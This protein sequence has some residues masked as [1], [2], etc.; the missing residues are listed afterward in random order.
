[1]T[2]LK[3]S[4]VAIAAAS[5]R[6]SEPTTGIQRDDSTHDA[7]KRLTLQRGSLAL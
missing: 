6:G 7:R 3:R 5:P 1:M 4:N 2:C